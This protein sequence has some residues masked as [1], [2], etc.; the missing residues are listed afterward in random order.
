[1]ISGRDALAQIEHAIARARQDENRLDAALRQASEQAVRLRAERTEA[2]RE[3]ARLKL[4]ALPAQ[5]AEELDAVERRALALLADR[6][7][8]LEQL[9]QRRQAAEAAVQQAEA[10]RHE[11]AAALERALDALQDRRTEVEAKTRID[12][13]WAAQRARVDEVARMAEQAEKKARQAEADRVEKGRPYEADPLFMYLWRRR[14]GTGEYR[15][16]NLV[17]FFDRKVAHLVGYDKARANYTMLNEIPLRLREHAE[18]VKGEIQSE[19]A[20]LTAIEREALRQGGIEPLEAAAREVKA[21]LDDAEARLA[22][23]R[24]D[25]ADFD[26]A[27]DTTVLEGDMP[28][29]EAVEM[30]AQADAQQDLQALYRE[31]VATPT[32]RDE[33]IVKRIE[34]LEIGIGRAEQEMGQIRRQMQE[35]VQRRAAIEQQRDHFRQ[36][37]YDNP[38]GGFGNEAVLSNVLGGILGGVI[39]GAVLGQ[40]LN[41]G[42]HRRPGPWDSDFGG[43]AFPFPFPQDGGGGGFFPQDGGGGWIGGGGGFETGGTIGGGGGEFRTG[44]GF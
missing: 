34:A 31:A 18:R 36:R 9:T 8:A 11:R 13:A 35:L 6:R 16:S 14:F 43:G 29:R 28:F 24:K 39:Q 32:P 26:R 38:Y 21:A 37:G 27:H 40:V 30:L 19:R 10:A 41:Q 7:Q 42:Y 4:D 20:R 1:M 2:F 12:P 15:A 3:L 33:A 23:A 25:L 44:G 17:R 22:E 5:R